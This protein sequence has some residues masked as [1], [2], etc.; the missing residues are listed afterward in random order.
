MPTRADRHARDGEFVADA[1]RLLEAARRLV[2]AAVLYERVKGTGWER[3][4]A[5]LGDLDDPAARVRHAAA[6]QD[7]LMRFLQAWLW[8]EQAGDVLTAPDQLAGLLAR[9]DAW[10]PGEERDDGGPVSGGLPA[11]GTRER[12][13]LLDR[14]GQLLGDDRLDDETRL[15]LEIALCRRRIEFYED[16]GTR[17]PETLDALAGTRLRLRALLPAGDDDRSIRPGLTRQ[18]SVPSGG[19]RAVDLVLVTVHMNSAPVRP[20]AELTY[21]AGPSA[22]GASLC[23][24]LVG[25][26]AAW[27]MRPRD[28]CESVRGAGPSTA[29]AQACAWPRPRAAPRPLT[30][31]G[32]SSGAP[33]CWRPKP[34]L[35]R[36]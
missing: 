31:T 28:I 1:V 29:G 4:A 18:P 32:R 5:D 15:G 11:M 22:G 34:S 13:A 3:V 30:G 9:L 12:S 14:A 36:G 17:S 33:E 35:G 21:M 2:D 25:G 19:R 24:A 16:M 6:E 20:E 10:A 26:H 23:W 7:F 8:P 27:I